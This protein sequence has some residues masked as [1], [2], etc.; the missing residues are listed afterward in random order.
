MNCR[1]LER[2]SQGSKLAPSSLIP[3]Q[4][5]RDVHSR[6]VSLRAQGKRRRK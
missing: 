4:N 6:T 1:V 5:F 2:K 3:E